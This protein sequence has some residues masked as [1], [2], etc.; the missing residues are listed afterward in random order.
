MILINMRYF[1]IFLIFFVSCNSKYYL[2]KESPCPTFDVP[3]QKDKKTR[4]KKIPKYTKIIKREDTI[5][6]PKFR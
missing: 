5:I 3:F 1:F 2:Y 6:N 4:K